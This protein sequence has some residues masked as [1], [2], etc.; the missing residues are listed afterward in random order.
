MRCPLG[1]Q[2]RCCREMVA[3]ISH[4][5]IENSNNLCVGASL[6]DCVRVC[7]WDLALVPVLLKEILD[8]LLI[9]KCAL[10]VPFVRE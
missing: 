10:H 6:A 4:T 5:D 3:A 1:G 8:H 2:V 7:V 9:E